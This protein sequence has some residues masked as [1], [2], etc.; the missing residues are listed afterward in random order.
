MINSI[1]M[2]GEQF[3]QPSGKERI[4]IIRLGKVVFYRKQKGNRQSRKVI[5]NIKVSLD[6]EVTNNSFG[7][8]VVVGRFP[9]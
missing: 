4:Y 1:Y 5:K 2:P 8:T 7:Y 9:T 3:Y 6:T